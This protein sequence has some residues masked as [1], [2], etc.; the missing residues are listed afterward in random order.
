MLRD[1]F[2]IPR[3]KQTRK[4]QRAKWLLKR[5][6]S[7]SVAAVPSELD[8]VVTIKE[9]E[10]TALKT[11]HGGQHVFSLLQAGFSGTLQRISARHD[12]VTCRREQ[13]G[14]LPVAEKL[15]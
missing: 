14:A 12:E 3:S 10:R 4:Q 7:V 6:T 5:F 15:V 9:E 13:Q 1:V 2:I 8:G 11:F